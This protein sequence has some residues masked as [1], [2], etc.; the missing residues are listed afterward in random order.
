MSPKEEAIRDQS[1]QTPFVPFTMVTYSGERLNVVAGGHIKFAPIFQIAQR[2]GHLLLRKDRFGS[3]RLQA[4]AGQSTTEVEEDGFQ[5]LRCGRSFEISQAVE[6]KLKSRR[7]PKCHY[8]ATTI[9]QEKR[10]F[11]GPIC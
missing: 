6:K 7:G 5:F 11:I 4:C 10:S 3:K 2:T 8:P 1:L 9:I